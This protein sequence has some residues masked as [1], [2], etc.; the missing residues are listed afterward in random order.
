VTELVLRGHLHAA[1]V[2]LR[3]FYQDGASHL[4]PDA[5]EGFVAPIPADE[6]HDLMGAYHRRLFGSDR[7]ELLRCA[8]RLVGVGA[9]DLHARP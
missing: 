8:A 3:F 6:R 2:E 5:W 1:A 7:D 9:R 4:F